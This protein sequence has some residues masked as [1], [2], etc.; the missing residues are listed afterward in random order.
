MDR[1]RLLEVLED[2]YTAYY[3]VVKEGLPPE[4]PIVFRGDFFKQTESYWISKNIPI[5]RNEE[6]EYSY[7]FSAQS[8][9]ADEVRKCLDFALEDGLPRVTPHKEHQ[10]TNIKAIFIADEFGEGALNEIENRR[11]SKS[12]HMSLWGYTD[13][14]TCAVIPLSE[15]VRTNKAGAEQK[16]FFKKLFSAEEKSRK[17]LSGC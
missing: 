8:L 12:Y 15:E 6:N 9:N 16:K 14:L 3:N 10:R 17:K 2:S 5:Y 4:L 13:L 11:Y 1:E 7:I